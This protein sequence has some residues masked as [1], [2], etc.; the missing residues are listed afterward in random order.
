MVLGALQTSQNAG[1]LLMVVGWGVCHLKPQRADFL[2]RMHCSHSQV[3]EERGRQECV[4]ATRT[5][6]SKCHTP[7]PGCWLYL[8]WEGFVNFIV[9]RQC[10]QND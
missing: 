5:H 10:V 2:P 3:R 7:R 8:S 6:P 4:P 9:C 1:F